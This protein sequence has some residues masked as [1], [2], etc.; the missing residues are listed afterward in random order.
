[1]KKTPPPNM[2][3]LFRCFDTYNKESGNC[4]I[5]LQNVS[6]VQYVVQNSNLKFIFFS[7]CDWNQFWCYTYGECVFNSHRCDGNWDCS[8]G[9]DELNCLNSKHSSWTKSSFFDTIII[10][11]SPA[12]FFGFFL[13][14][15]FNNSWGFFHYNYNNHY[16]WVFFIIGFS[17]PCACTRGISNRFIHLSQDENGPNW[18]FGQLQ[19][20]YI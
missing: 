5:Q 13:G 8:D 16:S 15:F 9:S 2:C 18:S 14:Y 6:Y 12:V 20:G 10:I 4:S 1:M 17:T 11:M 19:V 3:P 7:G